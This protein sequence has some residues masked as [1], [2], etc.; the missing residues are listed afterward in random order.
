MS[1]SVRPGYR[2]LKWVMSTCLLA[3]S[4]LASA[5]D[6]SVAQWPGALSGAGS[7]DKSTHLVEVHQGGVLSRRM[8]DLRIGGYDT[9]Q[10][11]SVDFGHWYTTRWADA[12]VG[13]M[14]QL[15]PNWGLLWG[16]G[17]G[18]R[19]PKYSISP[20]F[21]L[22]L[23]YVTRPTRD[24]QF[25]LRG[26]TSVGGNLRERACTGDYGAVAGVQQVNCRLAAST[27]A[28][29]DTL[30]YLNRASSSERRTL[31]IEYRIQF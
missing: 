24:S 29:A 26:T 21:K 2:G 27:L 20:S 17:T 30:Q 23:L 16:F 18:E 7:G 13:W 4:T 31:S 10:G 8:S 9:A 12:R 6:W 15:N 11:Q 28:P 5:A 14:S 19:A 3:G 1:N 22:G 25:I